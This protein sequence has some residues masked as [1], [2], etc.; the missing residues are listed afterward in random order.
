MRLT[1]LT[2][3]AGCLWCSGCGRHELENNAFPLALG[4][5]TDGVSAAFEGPD[6]PGLLQ[7]L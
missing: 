2:L 6:P 3:A 5:G 4:I 7:D 1:C